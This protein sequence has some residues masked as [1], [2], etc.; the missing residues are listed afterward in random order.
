[1][2]GEESSQASSEA[3]HRKRMERMEYQVSSLDDHDGQQFAHGQPRGSGSLP[4]GN[5]ECPGEQAGPAGSWPS[6]RA[7][8][9]ADGVAVEGRRD[10]AIDA[11][12]RGSGFRGLRGLQGAVRVLHDAAWFSARLTTAAEMPVR[13]RWECERRVG[14]RLWDG[15]WRA[16]RRTGGMGPVAK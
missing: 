9:V 6:R 8:C 16:W 2:R 11:V 12:C 5:V 10:G 4:S 1:M 14:S 3:G 15:D 7:G 13:W